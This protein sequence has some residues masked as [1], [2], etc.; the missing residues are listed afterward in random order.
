[1]RDL[2]WWMSRLAPWSPVTGHT[3]AEDPWRCM[4]TSSTR[5]PRTLPP[6]ER[7]SAPEHRGSR[8]SA[9]TGAWFSPGTQLTQTPLQQLSAAAARAHSD[10]ACPQL[11]NTPPLRS[12]AAERTLLPEHTSLQ[13]VR[14]SK[15]ESAVGL[16]L[17]MTRVTKPFV[18][19]FFSSI[20][21]VSSML[22]IRSTAAIAARGDAMTEQSEKMSAMT[23]GLVR[24]TMA[25]AEARPLEV[26][27]L[28]YP[29][30]QLRQSV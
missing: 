5:L 26:F 11:A 14:R 30:Y 18:S 22:L 24:A 25:M 9:A 8:H 1:M 6:S 20:S 12:P 10:L 2:T 15:A 16:V 19:S 29:S 13:L 21:H 3:C 4:A 7:Y 28:R 27:A 23:E 17:C